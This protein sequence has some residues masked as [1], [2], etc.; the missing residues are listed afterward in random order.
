MDDNEVLGRITSLHARSTSCSSVNLTGRSPTLT[1][2]GYAGS[3]SR[4][5]SAGTCS[6]KDGRGGRRGSTRTKLSFETRKPSRDTR[7]DHGAC[8]PCS[9]IVGRIPGAFAGILTVLR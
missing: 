6:G 4:W 8:V 3:R 9:P 7:P 5:I 1:V 2:N